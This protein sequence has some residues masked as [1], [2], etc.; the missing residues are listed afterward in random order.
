MLLAELFTEAG[1]PPGLVNVIHGTH[2]AV[3]F[4]CD[5]EDI[6]AISFVGSDTAVS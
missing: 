1:A 3:N 2:D 4:I 6:K 5:H